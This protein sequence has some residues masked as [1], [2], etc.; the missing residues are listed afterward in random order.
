MKNNEMTNCLISNRNLIFKNMSALDF[1]YNPPESPVRKEEL[2]KL[3]K[4]FEPVIISYTSQFA[5]IHGAVGTGKTDMLKRFSELLKKHAIENRVNVHFEFINCRYGYKNNEVI[6]K[7]LNHFNPDLRDVGHSMNELLKMLGKHLE[8]QKVHV[9]LVIDE[10]DRLLDKHSSKLIQRLSEFND[11]AM[12]SQIL[13]SKK[14]VW[15]MLTPSLRNKFK[16][17]NT[18]HLNKFSR[19]EILA[20]LNHRIELAFH[21]DA[22]DIDVSDLISDMASELGD[23]RYAIELL[24]KAGMIAVEEEAESVTVEHARSA[25]ADTYSIITINKLE[26]RELF[27]KLILLA[28]AQSLRYK[29]YTNADEV[30]HF[31]AEGCEGFGLNRLDHS[32]FLEGLRVLGNSHI[33]EMTSVKGEDPERRTISLHDISAASLE[34]KLIELYCSDKI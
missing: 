5:I 15:G 2:L 4:I 31:Y 24:E 21:E 1:S 6:L 33:I 28:V 32:S 7:I 30:E 19:Q 20:I 9:I 12:I 26:A 11:K 10:A 17:E 13:V 23:V 8:R 3:F 27:E 14:D 25:K 34:A 16:Q 22:V 29:A 18:I